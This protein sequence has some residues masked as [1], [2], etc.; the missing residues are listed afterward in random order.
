MAHTE[1]GSS[2]NQT[3][4]TLFANRVTAIVVAFIVAILLGGDV[5]A[6]RP[7]IVLILA[8]DVSAD[9]FSCYGQ[10]GA[11][12]TPNID[13]IAGEGV[14]FRTCFAPAI[15]GP[16]RA[17]LMTGVYGNRTGAF[18]N[19]MWAFDSRGTLF[20]AQHSW[21]KLMRDGGYKTAVA[22]KWHCGAREPWDANVG[23]DEYCMYEGPDKIKS[24]FGIDV[25]ANGQ[26]KDIKLPDV[27]YWYSSMIQNGKYVEVT[28]ND[29][30][31][32]QRCDFLMDFM[33]RKANAKEPF[34]AYWPTVI[35]HGP[36]STT[37]DAG[38]V[39]DIELEKPDTSGM[40]KEEKTR[41]LAQYSQKQ[42]E[43]F[44]NLIQ[45]MDKLIG[46]LIVKAEELRIYDNTYFIFCADNGTAVTAKDRGVERGVHVPYVVK[47]PGVTRRGVTH[48]LTD[49]A[50]IAPTLL[51]MAGIKHPTDVAFD[52]ASQLPFLTR[53]TDT[54]RPWIYAYTGPVQVFRTQSHLLEARSPFYGQPNGRFYFTGENR[55]GRGYQRV[56]DKPEHA[57]QRRA[58]EDIIQSLPS[59]LDADHPFW[60]SKYGK[61]WLERNPDRS[62]LAAKQLYNHPDY[63][64][65]DETM[66]TP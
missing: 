15:C 33:E 57:D 37:P 49:F 24:H 45:Y 59:H 18:R 66:D 60:S 46:K 31:P 53:A 29:F 26:R 23:F 38:A 21:A 51:D 34:V 1:R 9:M 3:G 8:D 32:D 61:R 55:Y 2:V 28:E 25:I 30:G 44:V 42:Q 52:G 22:G 17:L 58:F 43:R 54:H 41:A 7:N 10:P 48:A 47:G 13:R 6:A 62:E 14:Q 39:M 27:R 11:A 5:R 50:D 63:R 40:S 56:E 65:Y 12:K 64:R 16:S 20:T 36:Y 4:K 35:P 19:D